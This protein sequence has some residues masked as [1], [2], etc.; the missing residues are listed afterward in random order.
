MSWSFA[1]YF[2]PSLIGAVL[3]T[4]L[5]LVAWRYRAGRRPGAGPGIGVFPVG[6][7]FA[8]LAIGTAEWALCNSLEVASV[9]LGAKLL[10]ARIEYIGIVTVP[11]AW[12]LFALRFTGRGRLV[13]GWRALPLAIVPAITLG[14]VLTD[15]G[16]GLIWRSVALDTAGPVPT[17]AVEH[18]TW[19][20]VHATYSYLAMLAGTVLML[21]AASRAPHLYGDQARAIT[22][23]T[24]AVWLAN[25]LSISGLNPLG[26]LD[27]TPPALALGTLVVGYAVFRYRFLDLIP[28]AREAVVEAMRDGV[29]VLD[30]QGRVVD[31]NPAA[32]AIVGNRADSVI[33]QPAE[34]VLGEAFAGLAANGPD[35]WQRELARVVQGDPRSYEV[36]LSRLPHPAARQ[37]GGDSI[38][39]VVL[40]HDITERR[41][42]EDRLRQLALYDPL[43]EL[44]NRRLLYERIERAIAQAARDG[45]Q[46]TLLVLDLDG[47]KAVNDTLGHQA[48]DEVLREVGAR[49]RMALRESDTVARLGGDEF[50]VLLPATGLEGGAIVRNRITEALSRPFLPAAGGGR[51]IQIGASIG[52]AAYPEHG[53]DPESLLRYA[54]MAMYDAKHARPPLERTRG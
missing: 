21:W 54:D 50:S 12:L 14:L 11:V 52:A 6:T 15:A 18:G 2:V 20:W 33:G 16:L 36:R 17:L 22:I 45:R 19:F 26:R 53:H 49:L 24:V 35:D 32:V 40:L 10:W 34:A 27:L 44:P 47:F 38:G 48:G 41:Q 43:T 39:Y 9:D 31:L 51:P 37:R 3:A 4:A 28:V 23:G 1:P 46:L 8:L 13:E 29:V 30:P 42:A 25:A 7:T 5:A